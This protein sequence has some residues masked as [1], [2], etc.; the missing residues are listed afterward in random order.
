MKRKWLI[1]G[2]LVFLEMLVCAGILAV[3]WTGQAAIKG[4]RLVY[5]ADTHVEGTE[6][7]TFAVN[8]PAVVDLQNDFGDV[9]VTG[10]D[11]SEVEVI[12]RLSLWGAD[13]EDARRQVDVQMNQ[14]GDRITIR[15]IRPEH[16]YAFA[17]FDRGWRVEFEIRVPE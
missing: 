13:E 17:F 3:A 16:L 11:G 8:G 1:V 10:S 7:R 14:V 12:A 6:E 5:V 4:V 2:I 15:L 9:A